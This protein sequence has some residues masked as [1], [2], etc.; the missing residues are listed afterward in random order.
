MALSP[1][2][3]ALT[4]SGFETLKTWIC[5]QERPIEIQDF[6][7]PDLIAGDCSDLVAYYQKALVPHNAHRGIHG[8]FFG[9]DLANPD[10]DIRA[11]VQA[12][13]LKA[14]EIAEALSA[15]HMVIHS[16]F[17]YWDQLNRYNYP[18]SIPAMCAAASDC[19]AAVLP[20]AS[21]IGCDLVIENIEDSDPNLRRTLVQQ[22]DHPHLKLSID[23]GHADLA[24]G[25]F[26]APPVVD[27][28][29]AAAGHLGH[30][31]L[32]DADG[33]ADRHWHPG[34]GRIAWQPIL[35]AI[36]ELDEA[37]HLILEVR[38]Q[39]EHLPHTAAWLESLSL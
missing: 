34:Q 3:V 28:I 31:H 13:F 25:C 19:L 8:P 5:D 26:H 24:H 10:R 38:D 9:L 27:F 32:Q 33:Y 37:P 1:I 39:I 6:V 12:R 21:D 17:S 36:A 22:I 20:R 30:V 23:T 14:L 16:P 7:A 11:I 29:T 4:R 35:K 15:K 2:G 18:E